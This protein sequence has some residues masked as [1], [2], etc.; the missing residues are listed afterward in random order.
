MTMRGFLACYLGTM[1]AVAV[2]GIGAH[3][4]LR[5]RPVVE[6][7]APMVVAEQT[8]DVVPPLAAPS[9]KAAA[10]QTPRPHRHSAA[11]RQVAHRP[12]HRPTVVGS[13]PRAI[14]PTGPYAAPPPPP[15]P[16]RYYV[17]PAYYPYGGYYPPYGYR[18]F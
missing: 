2:A 6:A 5:D 8:L 13:L 12:V 10:P 7:T 14:Y 11:P 9:V 17:D 1:T 4:A 16:G 18:S 3:Q 15:P